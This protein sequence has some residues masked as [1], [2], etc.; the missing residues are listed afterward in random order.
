[1]S[2]LV[3]DIVL[4]RRVNKWND[5]DAHVSVLTDKG[6]ATNFRIFRKIDAW[7]IGSTPRNPELISRRAID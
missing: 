5:T 7:G 1:M 4:I 2:T 6:I 3:H